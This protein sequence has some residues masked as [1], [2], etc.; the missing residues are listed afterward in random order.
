MLAKLWLEIKGNIKIQTFKI[1]N[2]PNFDSRI[3]IMIVYM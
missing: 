3:K 1:D 2:K